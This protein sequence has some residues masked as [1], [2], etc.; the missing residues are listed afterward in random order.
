[1]AY[2]TNRSRKAVTKESPS[3]PGLVT[4]D[5][6]LNLVDE[7]TKADLLDG[8]IV[9]DS[10]AVPRHAL[11][12][13][14]VTRLLGDFAERCDLGV[15]LSATVTVR[16]TRY[17]GPEPDVL[18]IRRDRLG[19]IGEK[20]VDGPPDLC[21]EVVSTTSEKN[22]RGRKFVLY[23]DHSVRE[24]WI[25]DPIRNSVEL[26]ENQDGAWR[27]IPVD[28]LG[29]FFSKVLPGLWL[30]PE[31][32]ASDPLPPVLDTLKAILYNQEDG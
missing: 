31:W 11:I 6:F 3:S 4:F 20:Y 18:F 7:T 19:I 17:Q 12:V 14:W 2:D 9:R 8:R 23:A 21:V 1:M 5:Q 28:N 30:R 10:P 26:Y 22:D 29:R 15:V 16:L 24:Y 27:E 13:T 25:L 32:I